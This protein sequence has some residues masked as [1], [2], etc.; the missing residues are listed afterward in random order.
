MEF[1]GGNGALR[2]G[3]G[4]VASRAPRNVASLLLR[5]LLA[6]GYLY[7]W[8]AAGAVLGFNY[9]VS[10]RVDTTLRVTPEV[11]VCAE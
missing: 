10:S 11:R 1:G 9:G 4:S 8:V 7:E 5:L 2:G 3:G 6:E